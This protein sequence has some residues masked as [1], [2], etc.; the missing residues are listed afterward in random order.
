MYPPVQ[1]VAAGTVLCMCFF[2]Q[3]WSIPLRLVIGALTWFGTRRMPSLRGPLSDT[4]VVQKWYNGIRLCPYLISFDRHPARWSCASVGYS[5]SYL[6]NGVTILGE[7][8]CKHGKRASSDNARGTQTRNVRA[9]GTKVDN[10]WRGII[11][12]TFYDRSGCRWK[13]HGLHPTFQ[14]RR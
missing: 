10:H 5:T 4:D 7:V 11:S 14:V 6:G 2:L 8:S 13:S 9:L 12:F 3:T 1:D